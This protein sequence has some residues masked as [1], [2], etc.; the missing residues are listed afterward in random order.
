M[1]SGAFRSC[2]ATTIYDTG[3]RGLSKVLQTSDAPRDKVGP[4]EAAT[5]DFLMLERHMMANRSD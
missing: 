1:V 5:L 4:W 3:T 2:V